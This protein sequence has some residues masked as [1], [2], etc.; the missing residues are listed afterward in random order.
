MGN[1]M[2]DESRCQYYLH[3]D[4]NGSKKKYPRVG[5]RKVCVSYC[6]AQTVKPNSIVS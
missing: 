4:A 1:I 5:R 2:D 6:A 3:L